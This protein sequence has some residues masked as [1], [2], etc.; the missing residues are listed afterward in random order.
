MYENKNKRFVVFFVCH[1]YN[2]WIGLIRQGFAPAPEVINPF[3]VSYLI[4]LT[5]IPIIYANL[6]LMQDYQYLF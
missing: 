3:S 1:I 2:I 6:D 5:V 4:I